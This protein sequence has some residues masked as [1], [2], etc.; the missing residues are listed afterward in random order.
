MDL[1]K[2]SEKLSEFIPL[3]PEKKEKQINVNTNYEYIIIFL[4][5]FTTK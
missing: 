3:L 1:E 5:L 2:D 4:L